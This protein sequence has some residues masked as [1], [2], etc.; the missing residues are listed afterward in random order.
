MKLKLIALA[1]I[2]LL[3]LSL[4]ACAQANRQDSISLTYD[5]F[6][7]SKSQ[8]RPIEAHIGDTIV[9]T[10]PSNATTGY[11]WA[12]AGI[13]DKTVV[14]QEGKSQYVL[15]ESTLIGAGGQEIWTFKTLKRGTSTISLEYSQAW[16][17]GTK[18]AWTFTAS[19]TVK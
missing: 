8:S 2:C 11:Q 6:T 4:A 18:G 1:V 9:V 16:Q 7:Q 10:L 13:S 3:A 14:A 19:V 5:D 12:L 15:P 17:G